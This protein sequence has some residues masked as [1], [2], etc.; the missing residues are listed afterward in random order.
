LIIDAAKSSIGDTDPAD[1]AQRC[2]SRAAKKRRRASDGQ[3]KVVPRGL[4]TDE[5]LAK[6]DALDWDDTM[7]PAAAPPAATTDAGAS[8]TPP[9]PRL[10]AVLIGAA[11]LLLA[12][13]LVLYQVLVAG[14]APRPP[15]NS[16]PLTSAPSAV[17]GA[18]VSPAASGGD[19]ADRVAAVEAQERQ[20][21]AK[22]AQA[23]SKA[24]ENAL[25]KAEKLRKAR[26]A[27]QARLAQEQ[28]QQERRRQEE[29]ARQRA[30]RE[31]AEARARVP[32]PAPAPVPRG[33]ASPQ[34]LCAAESNFFSRGLCE[35]RACGRPEWQSHP[36]CVKRTEDQL[37]R[38]SPGG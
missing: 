4:A 34:E 10:P 14:K 26:E 13:G 35:G 15:V 6:I 5:L 29:E 37:R 24:E 1:D 19:D 32:A 7:L 21:A 11:A 9:R 12:G 23:V 16:N 36:F 17:A 27:E 22:F 38:I 30:E 2:A 25:R 31:A 33:P 28:Q 8:T 18:D 20:R 3:P